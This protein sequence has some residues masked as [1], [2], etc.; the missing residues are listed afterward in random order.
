VQRLTGSR[1]IETTVEAFDEVHILSSLVLSRDATCRLAGL[2]RPPTR[3]AQTAAE[4][5]IEPSA[6]SRR[7]FFEC[8]GE[9]FQPS[10][11][12]F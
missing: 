5:L 6:M 12:P 10:F 7:E 9:G 1:V 2:K 8:A 3:K 11:A 4:T